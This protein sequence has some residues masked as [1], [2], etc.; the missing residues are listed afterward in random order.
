LIWKFSQ[1]ITKRF[2]TDGLNFTIPKSAIGEDNTVTLDFVFDEISKDELELDT[3]KRT[4]TFSVQSFKMY[5][6]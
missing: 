4:K 2:K 3:N 5:T 6:Q 1:K